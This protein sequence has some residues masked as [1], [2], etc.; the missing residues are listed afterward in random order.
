[1]WGAERVGKEIRPRGDLP[2]AHARR[3]AAERVGPVGY[4]RQDTRRRARVV[5]GDHRQAAGD[6]AE[7]RASLRAALRDRLHRHSRRR[8][9]SRRPVA[10]RLVFVRPCASMPRMRRSLMRLVLAAAALGASQPAAAQPQPAR[11]NVL[12]IMADDLND[13]R[14]TLGHPLVKTPNLDRLAA[15]G[16]RFDRAYTQFPLCSP[17]RVSLLTGLRPDTTGVHDLVTDFRTVLPDVQTMPQMFKRNGYVTARVGKIFHYGNPGQI[18]TSGLDDPASWDAFVNPRG[19]D[20]DE[21]SL[22]TNLTPDRQLGN[23]LAYYA[24]PAPDE[25]H[26][27]GKVAAETIAL[28][29]KYKGQ[30]FFIG[31]GF[32]RP[33]CPFIAPKK[34]FDLYPMDKIAARPFSAEQMAQVPAAALFTTPANWNLTVDQ[35]RETIRAYYASISFLD[36]QVGRVLDALALL[37]LP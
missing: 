24:S 21:E 7:N 13:D 18:G 10:A 28:L 3:P 1:F 36:A 2:P 33:H 19:I 14:G 25:A 11:P 9:L 22:L 4:R 23:A 27:D 5:V 17:S 6:V 34:Y 29:E 8:P 30:P 12:L 15:R 37:P 16:V 20:K 35:Q 32:Y 26:T 31:A